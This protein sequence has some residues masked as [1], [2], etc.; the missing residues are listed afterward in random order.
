MPPRVKK[1]RGGCN[2]KCIIK[3][4]LFDTE[5]IHAVSL[6]VFLHC[7][8]VLLTLYNALFDSV[9]YIRHSNN[10]IHLYAELLVNFLHGGKLAV[11]APLHSVY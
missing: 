10:G 3:Y 9:D 8:K 5:S 4:A 1:T 7:G 11:Q 2:F 6:A